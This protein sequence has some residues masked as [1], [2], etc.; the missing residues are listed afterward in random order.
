MNK[1]TFLG[2][3][4]LGAQDVIDVA[5]VGVPWDGGST[6]ARGQAAAPDVIRAAGYNVR[7][8]ES[9]FNTTTG[10]DLSDLSIVDAGDITWPEQCDIASAYSTIREH[11]GAL[12]KRVGF[13]VVLG[14][15]DGINYPLVQALNNLH[16]QPVTLVHFDAHRDTWFP[17]DDRPYDHGTWVRDLID[18]G[19][20]EGNVHQLGVRCYGP[21]RDEWAMYGHRITTY[22]PDVSNSPY[23]LMRDIDGPVFIALDIDAVD[24]AFAPGTGFPEPGGFLPRDILVLL[25]LLARHQQVQGLSITEV[26][27]SLDGIHQPTARLANRLARTAIEAYASRA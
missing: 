13:T 4:R 10:T 8:G 19:M 24:P 12:F 16:Q 2:L 15:D 18:D 11:A 25:F 14:G 1:P 6:G 22:A 5:I 27:P 26:N 20:I 21:A 7:A 17:Q 23:F 9:L 3:P